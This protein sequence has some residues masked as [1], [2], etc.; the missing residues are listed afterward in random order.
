MSLPIDH[1][2]TDEIVCPHC[3][4]KHEDGGD[5]T[6]STNDTCNG[7][8]CTACEKSFSVERDFSVSYTT[9]KEKGGAK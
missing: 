3:G 8:E 7:M 5:W 6:W 4:H 1:W 2:H 9:W